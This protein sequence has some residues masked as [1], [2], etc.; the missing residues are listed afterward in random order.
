MKK[1]LFV[2]ALHSELKIA[3][4][5]WKKY[6]NNYILKADFLATWVGNL[7]MSLE[8]T[9]QLSQVDYDF[10]INFWVCWY[11]HTKDSC[12]QIVRSVY[13]PTWKE[14]LTPLFFEYAPLKSIFCSEIP[15]FK[16]ID[17]QKESFVDM[18]SYSFEK[19]C[20]SFRTARI[21]LKVP[22]DKVWEETK[23]FDISRA[24][25]FLES[26]LDFV[27]LTN[28]IQTYLDSLNQWANNTKYYDYFVFTVSERVIFEKYA[29]AYRSVVG[30]F[31]TFF[32][33]YKSIPKKDFLRKLHKTLT[34]HKKL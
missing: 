18:E 8:L 13:G 23:N 26:E 17:L 5:F 24:L 7:N 33:K 30:N 2:T 6:K 10:I 29:D 21:I 20:E 22:I 9:K 31:D 11:A 32:Q 4:N 3:K 1:L 28:Q 19:V 14:I 16:S 27:K 15:I 12:I 25:S 34:I